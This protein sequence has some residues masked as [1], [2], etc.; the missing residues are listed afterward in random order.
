MMNVNQNLKSVNSKIVYLG[1]RPKDSYQVH[2]RYS[3]IKIYH[4]P[5][6]YGTLQYRRQRLKYYEK[7]GQNNDLRY[8][9]RKYSNT[10]SNPSLVVNS[11]TKNKMQ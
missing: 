7:Q 2:F 10:D 1:F 11:P 4:K 3:R 5:I 6:L 9:N 8:E